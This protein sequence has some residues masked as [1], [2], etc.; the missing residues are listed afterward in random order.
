MKV[1]EGESGHVVA[2]FNR[3]YSKV[4]KVKLIQ[5]IWTCSSRNKLM[6]CAQCLQWLLHCKL[7]FEFLYFLEP[8]RACIPSFDANYC[9]R[10]RN[11]PLGTCKVAGNSC[12]S[13][14]GNWCAWGFGSWRGPSELWR[15]SGVRLG[16]AVKI[17]QR[18]KQGLTLPTI[19]LCT[20]L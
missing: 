5:I 7:L 19:L 8:I 3:C 16:R 6:Y 12:T 13:G 20:P 17:W 1:D 2:C 14:T 9:A 4:F 10:L 18:V 11:L 15:Y